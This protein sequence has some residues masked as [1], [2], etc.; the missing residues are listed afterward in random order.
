[1]IAGAIAE[2]VGEGK[3]SRETLAAELAERF[4]DDPAGF[5]P[6]CLEPLGRAGMAHFLRQIGA[7]ET[8]DAFEGTRV[9]ELRSGSAPSPR[10]GAAGWS[11][12][13]RPERHYVLAGI[14]AGLRGGILVM[15]AGLLFLATAERL[16]PYLERSAT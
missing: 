4:R 10:S 8:R 3:A 11:D 14:A 12:Q 15:A 9:P 5:E 1:M 16:I 6:R 13:R 2:S 7:A